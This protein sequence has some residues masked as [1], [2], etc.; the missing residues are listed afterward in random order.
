MASLRSRH[1][2]WAL[3]IHYHEVAG[4]CSHALCSLANTELQYEV[5]EWE[6][7]CEN[8]DELESEEC[9][10]GRSRKWISVEEMRPQREQEGTPRC[11]VL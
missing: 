6:K 4:P 5:F 8:L 3:S 1:R 7:G 11:V 9:F 2:G 10:S